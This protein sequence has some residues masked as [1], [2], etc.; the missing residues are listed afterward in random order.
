MATALDQE[1][2]RLSRAA[3]AAIAAGRA[4]RAVVLGLLGL[5]LVVLVHRL[6]GRVP[7]VDR[8]EG[9]PLDALV[10]VVAAG[11][12]AWLG[13]R[14]S[15]LF[16]RPPRRALA[17]RLDDELSLADAAD[18]AL[19]AGA[20]AGPVA[21]AV[22]A[23]AALSLAAVPASRFGSTSR[24]G[25]R[26]P[27]LLLAVTLFLLLAPGV[28]GIGGSSGAGAGTELGVGRRDEPEPRKGETLTPDE[29][30]R[31]L[32]AHGKLRLDVP[33]GKKPLE[34][35]VRLTTDEP[36]P[37][38][39]EGTLGAIADE[40]R[41]FPTAQTLGAPLGLAANN[42]REFDAEKVEPLNA[43]LSPGKHLV[44]VRWEPTAPPYRVALESNEVEID[45]PPP[46]PS[47]SAMN[48]DEEKDPIPQAP[49]PEPPPPQP[50]PPTPPPPPPPPPAPPPPQGETAQ[51]PPDAKFHD[52]V[53]EPLSKEGEEVRKEK[54]VV[55]VKDPNAGS[56][57]PRL[58]PVDEALADVD[59]VLERAVAEERVSPADRAFLLRYLE[60]LRRAA[61]GQPK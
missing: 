35:R 56:A 54:A 58:V 12:L 50:P 4:R 2:S 26:L 7:F 31:W 16:S 45:V 1:L 44:R 36:L 37:A 48:P 43:A 25:R 23:R 13:G 46:Q 61:G 39:L 10:F 14:A 19:S 20:D 18:A 47:P 55:A 38:S 22:V 32:M 11:A 42:V 53:V 9:R 51:K 49:P 3:G 60:A 24:P 8:V 33:D 30:D 57:P 21:D 17:R 34:W 29:A 5:A 28:L 15:G 52:E 41:P 40:G 59:R 6:V 27:I